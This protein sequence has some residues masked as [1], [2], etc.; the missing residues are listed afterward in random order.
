MWR[1][2]RDL[3]YFSMKIV[4]IQN[5]IYL[6]GYGGANKANR[7]ILELLAHQG[8]RCYAITSVAY[9]PDSTAA[10]Y[11]AQLQRYGI[12]AEQDRESLRFQFHGVTVLAFESGRLQLCLASLLKEISP[13][14]V[15]ISSEDSFYRLLQAALDASIGR[16][17]YLAHTTLL[18]PFGPGCFLPNPRGVS[19]IRRCHAVMTISEYLRQYLRK[20]GDI[21]ARLVK[22]PLYGTGPFPRH[23][24]FDSG[25]ILMVNP[26]ALKGISI[27]EGLAREFQGASFAAVPTW[28]TT[29]ADLSLL[30][31]CGNVKILP[32]ADD[33][34]ELLKCTKILLVPSLWDEAFGMIAV[35]AMLRGIPVLASDVGGLS[36]AKLGIEYLLPVNPI[37]KYSGKFDA[38]MIP[39]PIVPDQDL[40]PWQYALRQLLCDRAHYEDVA[41]RS[42]NTAAE[43][44]KALSIQD[45][46]QA[47][48]KDHRTIHTH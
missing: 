44:L 30:R 9:K 22:V 26:C 46:E 21:E 37:R 41:N 2:L 4:L 25:D 23:G 38:R 31:S 28:G 24:C 39:E 5:S 14:W 15:I 43:F 48:H 34:D 10:D 16:V 1:L 6:P 33:I 3:K 17:C 32:Y 35:E 18:L 42:W 12:T 13:D 47:L 8:H 45:L 29:P 40:G 36:E 11:A 7:I 20:W 19:L 27:F